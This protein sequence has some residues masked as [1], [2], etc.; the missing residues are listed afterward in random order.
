MAL[1]LAAILKL[2]PFAIHELRRHRRGNL[3]RSL[4]KRVQAELEADP[5]LGPA[6][7]DALLNEWLYIHNDASGAVVIAGFLRDGDAVYLE[8]LRVRAR[9]LRARLAFATPQTHR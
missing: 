8:A 7:T 9:P 6:L 3:S 2:A 4:D 1:D 5:Q